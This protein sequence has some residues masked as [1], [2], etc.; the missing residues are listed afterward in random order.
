M[1]RKRP[2]SVVARLR[3]FRHAGRG[4]FGLLVREHNARIHAIATVLVVA[5]GVLCRLERWEWGLVTAAI[6]LVWTAE[7]LNASLEQLADAISSAPDPAIG[8]AKDLAAG[9]VL[10][11]ALGAAGLGLV[12]FGPRL[13]ALVGMP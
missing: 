7:A 13:G 10:A 1:D 3:S 11:S 4:L 5:T 9:A 2:F 12:V 6:S 8:R